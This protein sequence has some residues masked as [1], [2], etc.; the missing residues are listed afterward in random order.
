MARLAASRPA[1]WHRLLLPG[2]CRCCARAWPGGA[3]G[4]RAR[5][6]ADRQAIL[7][8]ARHLLPLCRPVASG[9]RGGGDGIGRLPSHAAVDRPRELAL[10]PA[11]EGAGDPGRNAAAIER[12]AAGTPRTALSAGRC[13]LEL[14]CDAG[15]ARRAA[16]DPRRTG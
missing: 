4:D 15:A 2:H 14:R 13:T 3:L 6:R 12:R 1:E 5:A 16:P 8:S 7:G 11:A 9:P 10:L